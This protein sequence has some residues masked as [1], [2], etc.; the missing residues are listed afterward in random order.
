MALTKISGSLIK[1]DITVGVVTAT[2]FIGPLTG[3]VTGNIIAHLGDTDTK[4]RFPAADTITA[5]TGGSERLRITSAGLVGIGTD[6]PR[7]KL[8]VSAGRIIL[9]QDYQFTWANGTTNR[10]RIYGDSGNNFIVE[11]GS[12]NTERF[13]ITSAGNVGIGTD[14]PISG[15]LH[16]QDGNIRISGTSENILK[17]RHDSAGSDS[18][19]SQT[20]DGSLRYMYGA[21]ERLRITSDG[22][23]SIGTDNPTGTNPAK[24]TILNDPSTAVSYGSSDAF[25]VKS[26]NIDGTG[27]STVFAI[28]PFTP[29]SSTAGHNPQYNVALTGTWFHFDAAGQNFNYLADNSERTYVGFYTGTSVDKL[30]AGEYSTLND[31]G[32]SAAYNLA[33][34]MYRTNHGLSFERG[35]GATANTSFRFKGK[36]S[37]GAGNIIV[38]FDGDSDS[39]Q[40]RNQGNGD[41][42]LINPQQGNALNVY[43]GTGGCQ[44]WYNN[45][46]VRSLNLESTGVV[47]QYIY[48]TTSSNTSNSV[49]ITGGYELQR[50]TSSRRYK[51]NIGV[52]TGGLSRISTIVPRV[53]NDYKSDERVVGIV[54]EELHESGYTDAVSYSSWFGGSELGIG[55]DPSPMVGNGSTPVTKTGEELDDGVEVVDGISDRAIIC[56]LVLAVQELTSR[57]SALESN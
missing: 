25:V 32:T 9:D 1:S 46:T 3:D 52:Y 37:H 53:W 49:R 43:D 15:K 8:D 11:N 7:E 54:A 57:I 48:N 24:L 6:N 33:N 13:R 4:I 51:N 2:S 21:D 34:I 39:L 47:S 55:D 44:L 26:K 22:N 28:R 19:I 35:G 18:N 17:I 38:S 45:D 36:T 12:S 16:V 14:N 40:I 10:A 30:R 29:G 56:D 5:E 31:D 50:S 27:I 20:S 41:Y 42:S 23:V